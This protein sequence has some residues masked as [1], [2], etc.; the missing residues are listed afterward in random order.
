MTKQRAVTLILFSLLPAACSNSESPTVTEKLRENLDPK[1]GA[2]IVEAQRAFERGSYA[3]ALDFTDS[4]EVYAP[5][6]ADLHYIR[7]L[8]YQ[9]KR[10]PRTAQFAY[11]RVLEL[12]PRYPGA[13]FGLGLIAFRGSQLREAEKY[14]NEELEYN[15]ASAVYHE[16][17]RT[18]A[19][20]AVH[21]SA[22]VAYHKAIELDSTNSTAM[23]WLGQL[24]EELGDFEKALEWTRKGL[25][26]QPD[27][28]NYQYILGSQLQRS[29]KSEE[30]L[31]VLLPMAGDEP[32]HQ[33]IQFNTAQAL[34]AMG[35]EDEAQT[36]FTQ[37]DTAQQFRQRLNDAGDAVN[38]EPNNIE[39]WLELAR[40]RRMSGDFSGAIDAYK[41]AVSLEPF[42]MYLQSNLANLMVESGDYDSGIRRY[43]AI[44]RYDSTLTDVWMNLGVAYADVGR[45][46]LARRAWEE[47]LRQK[48]GEQRAK[49]FL[50]QLEDDPS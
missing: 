16:L 21:D 30:A 2:F 8:V 29:G 1:V 18:Y 40:L 3:M 39:V 23:M 43:R 17:G 25:E 19:K 49:S 32:L 14:Y 15:E 48:P 4:A 7:A 9:E 37:A 11:E 36:Y 6:L 24:Y 42:N 26:I 10:D 33:G 27:N 5:E 41:V 47:V 12:D 22:E 13:R 44:V 31:D 20:L 35:R 28:T 45:A 34:M 38:A 46:D 50:A